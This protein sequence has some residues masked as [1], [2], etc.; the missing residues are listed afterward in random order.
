MRARW[1]ENL[2]PRRDWVLQKSHDMLAIGSDVPDSPD[3][4]LRCMAFCV[5]TAPYLGTPTAAV[6]G[7]LRG[8][9]RKFAAQR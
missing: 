6:E 9:L 2:E 7:Y 8:M 4:A 1:G 5:D 3:E